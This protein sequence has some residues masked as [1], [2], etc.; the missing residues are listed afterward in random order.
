MNSKE[1]RNHNAIFRWLTSNVLLLQRLYRFQLRSIN[2]DKKP[3]I[4]YTIQVVLDYH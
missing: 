2:I 3:L 1:R 4:L